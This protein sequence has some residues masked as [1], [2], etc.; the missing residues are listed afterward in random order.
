MRTIAIV[1]QKG[2][3]GKTTTAI[4]LAAIFARRG[5]RTLLVDMDPQSHCAAGLAVPE[6]KL[7]YSMA[8][9]LLADTIDRIQLGHL[10]WEVGR[11]FDLAPSTTRL[12]GLEAAG[13]GLHQL[14]DKDRRLARV[15]SLLQH[16]YDRCLIDCPPTIGLLTFN[17]L[18]AA[19]EVIIPVETGFFALRGAEKQ[20]TTIQRT[21]E[22][23]DRPIACHMLATMFDP[24][25]NVAREI[26]ATLKRKFAGQILPVVIHEHESLREAASFGQPIIEYAFQSPAHQNFEE[27]A[28][29]LEDHP[30]S[31][32]VSIEVMPG[33]APVLMGAAVEGPG[34]RA[35]FVGPC[36]DVAAEA[37]AAAVDRS[38]SGRS[39][40]G[41][42]RAA[43]LAARVRDLVQ[44]RGGGHANPE[45]AFA[46]ATLPDQ[47]VATNPTAVVVEHDREAD[48]RA[49][50]TVEAFKADEHRQGVAVLEEPQHDA[51]TA[52]A[53]AARMREIFGV[54]QT[55]RGALF[56][57]PASIGAKVCVA[58]AFND[59]SATAMPLRHDAEL[60][61][62]T[63]MI[64]LA[65]GR[66]Q[67]R[68]V[69]DGRWQADRYNPVQELNS[70]SEPNSVLV[71]S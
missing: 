3:C 9:A 30:A 13:G 42:S 58:G 22:R 6:S 7:Q 52:M 51:T 47:P 21:I 66:Y 25:S 12:A 16:R 4:N 64:E 55:A 53:G 23:L 31:T 49:S 60:G 35:A 38:D 45:P 14:P 70:S 63:G 37:R 15:L 65:P 39:E 33:A 27:L 57:Q 24:S 59:W 10:I 32:E 34:Q 44:Q 29:W 36:D 43:E 26:L 2:G 40:A 68:L 1:N 61:V 50:V 48:E 19:R 28:D 56:V 54:R 18:R 69:I 71:I 67:Y 17:A 8:D 46:A 20:W 5:L 41:S 11:N 62:H